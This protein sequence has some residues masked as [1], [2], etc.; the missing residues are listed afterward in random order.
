MQ[1]RGSSSTDFL[2]VAALAFT[3]GGALT[4]GAGADFAPRPR[5]LRLGQAL[6]VS[7]VGHVSHRGSNNEG[8]GAKAQ[9]SRY[10]PLTG[11]GRPP[12][13]GAMTTPHVEPETQP[14]NPYCGR[15]HRASYFEVNDDGEFVSVCCAASPQPVE[16]PND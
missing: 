8:C 14:E 7:A 3:V 10:P 15:C 6:A 13:I 1:E 9:V 4:R 11:P 5:M 16:S 12:H 2:P